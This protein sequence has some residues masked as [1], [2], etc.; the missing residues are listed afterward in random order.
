MRLVIH[1]LKESSQ[2]RHPALR[3]I[4]VCH[5]RMLQ[6]L[7]LRERRVIGARGEAVEGRIGLLIHYPDVL[8][9]LR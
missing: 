5:L 2:R 9:L 8:V 3:K 1:L 4:P 7:V 6:D